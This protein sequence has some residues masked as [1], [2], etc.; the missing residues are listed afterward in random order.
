MDL[1]SAKCRS[2]RVREAR[3][4]AREVELRSRSDVMGKNRTERSKLGRCI[5]GMRRCWRSSWGRRCGQYSHRSALCGGPCLQVRSVR[6]PGGLCT[7]RH[8]S[9]QRVRGRMWC[10]KRGWVLLVRGLPPGTVRTRGLA[11]FAP[12]GAQIGKQGTVHSGSGRVRGRCPGTG[13]LPMQRRAG[14]QTGPR[15]G[16]AQ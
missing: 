1:A 16:V 11:A 8:S 13:C 7:P 14:I 5:G 2:A 3:N 9:A 12:R 4:L 10:Y 15:G 6:V